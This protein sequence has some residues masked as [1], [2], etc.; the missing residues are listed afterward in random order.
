VARLGMKNRIG[1]VSCHLKSIF[2]LEETWQRL[3]SYGMT[4]IEWFVATDYEERYGRDVFQK[5]RKSQEDSGII[6]SYHAPYLSEWNLASGSRQQ[7]GQKMRKIVELAEKLDA[8]S[9]ILHPGSFQ[10]D[11]NVETA[12]RKAIDRVVA[13]IEDILP[14]LI[15]KKLTLCLENN[16]LCYDPYALGTSMED[17]KMFFERLPAEVVGLNLDT[18]HSHLLG[19]TEELISHFSS[20]LFHTHLHDNDR[21]SDSHLPFTCGT[22]NWSD[23]FQRLQQKNYTGPLIL[24]FPEKS[25]LYPDFVAFI[26]RA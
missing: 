13:L 3:L 7:A 26:R 19:I 21:Q 2:P 4:E 14:E 6:A 9:V 25:G 16:S 22:F 8:T 10:P 23:F 5:I 12:R 1:V 18:G 17:F 24:E 15:K 11:L 20:R